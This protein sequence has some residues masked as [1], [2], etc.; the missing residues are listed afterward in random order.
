MVSL[1]SERK[2]R[3]LRQRYLWR[4]PRILTPFKLFLRIEASFEKYEKPRKPNS[5]VEGWVEITSYCEDVVSIPTT[6][7]WPKG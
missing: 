6:P 5:S 2:R 1:R 7:T 4:G 3:K